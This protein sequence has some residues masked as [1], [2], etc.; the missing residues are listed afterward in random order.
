MRLVGL[1]ARWS[2]WIHVF[3]YDARPLHRLIRQNEFDLVHAWEEPFVYAGYQIGRSLAGLPIPFCFRTAQ[4]I[5]KHYPPP[6]RASERGRSPEHKAGSPVV[7]SSTR[8][9]GRGAIPLSAGVS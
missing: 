2:R 8:R 9:C 6:F 3:H 4:S 5:V 1:D 7:V